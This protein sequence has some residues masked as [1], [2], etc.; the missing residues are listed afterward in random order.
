MKAIFYILTSEYFMSLGLLIFTYNK[1]KA[2]TKSIV[3]S[4]GVHW[5]RLPLILEVKLLTSS[6]KD[7][8]WFLFD[9]FSSATDYFQKF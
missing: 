1:I 3:Q 6:C 7:Q 2:M 4:P 5:S 9:I 8:V